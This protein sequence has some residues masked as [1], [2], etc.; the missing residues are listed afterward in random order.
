[1]DKTPRVDISRSREPHYLVAEWSEEHA[2]EK[3]VAAGWW[4][5]DHAETPIHGPYPSREA[6]LV[7]MAKFGE[8]PSG[9]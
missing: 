8:A 6:G 7:A 1:M 3:G 9:G 2:A 4:V 5:T